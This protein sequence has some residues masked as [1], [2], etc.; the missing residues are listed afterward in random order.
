MLTETSSQIA[1]SL[2]ALFNKSLHCGVLSDDWKLANVVPVHKRD[3]KSYVENYRPISLLPLISEVLERCVFQNIKHHVCQRIN[4]YQH[5]FIPQK[6]CISQLV[7]VFEQIGRKFAN[8]KQIDVIYFDVSKAFDKV[9]QLLRRLHEFGFR[10]NLLNWFSSYLSNRH[11]QTT[12][13]GVTSRSLPVTSGVPQGSILG[14][15]LFLLYENQLSKRVRYSGIAAIAYDTKIFK[16]IHNVSD[17]SLLQEDI[18]N[19]EE[20]SSKV[21]LIL[22][23]QCHRF[24]HILLLYFLAI[25]RISC[26]FSLIK[27]HKLHYFYLLL[28]SR[29]NR[30][31]AKSL[32]FQ[33][34]H[35]AS[36]FAFSML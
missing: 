21:N 28:Y 4:P 10:G 17:A 2:C 27:A 35:P 33:R 34:L 31:A 12:V 3:E 7:E 22:K 6:S 13:G 24:T 16:T 32:Q 23:E 8:E 9:S 18:K 15:L 26:R 29:D 5:G 14:P 25:L 19:F 30:C 36:I 11:Q 20:N 1:P